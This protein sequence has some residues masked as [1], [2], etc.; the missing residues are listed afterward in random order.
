MNEARTGTDWDALRHLST[1]EIHADIEDDPDAQATDENFW[2]EA[3]VIFPQPKQLVTLR[4]D[5]DLLA[6]L[7]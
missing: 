6:W 1:A 3:Q 4:L 2:K 7:K 5:A